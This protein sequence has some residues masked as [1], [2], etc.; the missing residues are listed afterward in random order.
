MDTGI[1][2]LGGGVDAIDFAGGGLP[3]PLYH[4]A[5]AR[6]RERGPVVKVCFGGEPAWMIT[7]YRELA[8]AFREGERFP[9]G[10]AY[11]LTTEPVVGRSFISMEG[12][13]HRVYRQLATPAFRAHTVER[14][15][16]SRIATVAHEIL[17]S[18]AERKEVDLVAA[19]THTFPIRIICR[20]LGLPKDDDDRF[21]RWAT[22]LLAFPFDPD[23]AR[24][25]GEEI[26]EYLL[27]IVFERRAN[28][29][30]DVIS[31]LVSA[32]VEDRQL[33]D[34][35][36]LS[37][38]R[39]LFPTGTETAFS[40][41]GNLIFAL[42][43][44]D[45]GYQRVVDDPS[46][47]SAAIDEVLRWESPV[48]IVPRVAASSPVEYAGVES[49]ADATVLFCIA[50]ANRDPRA[51]PDPDHYDLERDLG[52]GLDR[53]PGRVP[54]RE[55]Q[56]PLLSFGPGLRTCPGMHLARKELG[57]AL[58]VLCERLPEMRLLDAAEAQPTGTVLRGPQTLRVALR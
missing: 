42:L 23:Y 52:R 36:I 32:E 54:S 48:A 19:F 9:P 58:D 27:P 39:L 34:G 1:Q 47:R 53:K 3:G 56:S 21:I 57:I 35:E 11:A 49:P 30:E 5:L 15:E 43:D 33:S 50:A 40:A 29:R 28:P 41:L 8:A 7:R 14:Y 25:C 31:E 26:T 55:G 16:D 4:A 45:R 20:L 13:E 18:V 17:D 46:L 12:D 10:R 2:T 37:H 51:Y 38:I 22:G 24:S 44:R 6:L